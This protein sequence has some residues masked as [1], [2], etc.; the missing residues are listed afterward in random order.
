M[1]GHDYALKSAPASAFKIAKIASVIW[2]VRMGLI[3]ILRHQT[4]PSDL[5]CHYRYPRFVQGLHTSSQQKARVQAKIE[6][7][8]GMAV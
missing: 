3:S 1:I 2:M 5:Q 6:A 4:C 7:Y 8:P